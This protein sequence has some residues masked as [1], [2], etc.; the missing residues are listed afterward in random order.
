MILLCGFVVRL[1]QETEIASNYFVD[2]DTLSCFINTKAVVCSFA[3]QP[4][5]VF[6][7]TE[8]PLAFFLT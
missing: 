2:Y 6:S 3:Y 7:T 8:Y 4:R 5:N 1:L